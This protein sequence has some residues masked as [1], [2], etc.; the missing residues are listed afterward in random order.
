MPEMW[1]IVGMEWVVCVYGVG[2]PVYGVG[3]PVYGVGSD[4]SIL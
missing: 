4:G 3:Y 2:Y 1:L